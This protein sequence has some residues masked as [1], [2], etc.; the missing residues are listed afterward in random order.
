MDWKFLSEYQHNVLN[1]LETFSCLSM[2]VL[3]NPDEYIWSFHN[4]PVLVFYERCIELL[5]VCGD[6]VKRVKNH[7]FT[8]LNSNKLIFRDSWNHVRT[9]RRV[10]NGN[11]CNY[12]QLP[13]SRFNLI[14]PCL[15]YLPKTVSWNA[16]LRCGNIS[17][18]NKGHIRFLVPQFL[19][20]ER[21]RENWYLPAIL[22]WRK[23]NC[24]TPGGGANLFSTCFYQL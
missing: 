18:K 19:E 6:N 9:C 23:Q 10:T 1:L 20:I 17:I 14:L 15:Y 2:T 16:Q 12:K 24:A 22:Q 8:N 4:Q 21:Q 11:K 5:T 3:N 13:L 7:N